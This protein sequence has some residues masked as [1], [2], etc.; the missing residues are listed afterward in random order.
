MISV[1]YVAML[2]PDSVVVK[3]WCILAC[4]CINRARIVIGLWRPGGHMREVKSEHDS[5]DRED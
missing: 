1:K 2:Q 3:G 5:P 4:S